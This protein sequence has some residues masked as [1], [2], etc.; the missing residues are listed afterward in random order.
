MTSK[1]TQSEGKKRR[2]VWFLWSGA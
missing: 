1:V 2:G